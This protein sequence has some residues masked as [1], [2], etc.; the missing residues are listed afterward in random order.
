MKADQ[1]C[2]NN[3]QGYFWIND[4]TGECGCCLDGSDLQPESFVGAQIYRDHSVKDGDVAT[5]KK[6]YDDSEFT[7][8]VGFCTLSSGYE[9]NGYKMVSIETGGLTDDSCKA[10]C[11]KEWTNF[12]CIGYDFVYG[13]QSQCTL[14]SLD[15]RA[16]YVGDG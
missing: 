1:E 7:R 2:L 12:T 11:T 13:I 8:E 5:E 10:E 16:P 3:G 15:A 6:S 9:M 14:Y 4:W